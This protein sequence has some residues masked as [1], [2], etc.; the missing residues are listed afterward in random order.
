MSNKQ[1]LIQIFC[2]LYWITAN[3]LCDAQNTA[4]QPPFVSSGKYLKKKKRKKQQIISSPGFLLINF[5]QKKKRN[6]IINDD[7]HKFETV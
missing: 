3:N 5:T 2:L 7:S 6:Q 4:S 1:Q